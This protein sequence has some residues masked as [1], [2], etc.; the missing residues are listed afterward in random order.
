[1]F[2]FGKSRGIHIFPSRFISRQHPSPCKVFPNL[3]VFGFLEVQGH[4]SQGNSLGKTVEKLQG[5]SGKTSPQGESEAEGFSRGI[6]ALLR[7][8]FSDNPK[9]F[10]QFVRLWFSRGAGTDLLQGV[11]WKK[12]KNAAVK[13]VHCK[14]QTAPIGNQS[15]QKA[16]KTRSELCTL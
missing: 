2:A 4:S 14:S 8:K 1:M 5:L 12:F 3:S 11:V 9:A 7:V 10:Q 13:S 6:Q 15:L 16:Q